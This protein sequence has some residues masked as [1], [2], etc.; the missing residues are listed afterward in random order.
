MAHGHLFQCWTGHLFL[1]VLGAHTDVQN[2]DKPHLGV[3]L[4]TAFSADDI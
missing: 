1:A 3:V 4:G 2:S